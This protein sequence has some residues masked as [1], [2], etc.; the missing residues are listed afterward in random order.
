MVKSMATHAATR[1]SYVGLSPSLLLLV[2][3]C[4]PAGAAAD[5]P[6]DYRGEP[7]HDSA[8]HGAPQ[9]IPGRVQCAYYDLGGEGIAYH[10]SDA[11]NNG[12]GS[13]NPADG[14]YLNQFRM[15]EGVDT[16][17]TKYHDQI[18]NNPYQKVHPPEGLLYVGWTVAGEWFNMTV[19]VEHP[20]IYTVD[21]LYTSNAGGEISFDL[22]RNKL[23]DPLHITSTY[24]ATDP[25]AW[26][27]WHHWDVMHDLAEVTLPKGINVLT[28]HVVTTGNM[29][30]AYLDFKLKQ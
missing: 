15:G 27:Q 2:S 6:A 11:K 21:L 14:S 16:S 29:N 17:Y 28:L 19:D 7:Y 24:N 8:Y 25:I 9:K 23:T 13:L 26:R 4:V 18:D 3:L 5:K 10:D 30:F 20:G 1:S 12:S 22:N